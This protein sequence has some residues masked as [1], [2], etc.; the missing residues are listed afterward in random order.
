MVKSLTLRVH[1]VY[2]L[3]SL[4]ARFSRFND[5][6]MQF[7]LPCH[8]DHSVYFN[9]A[10]YLKCKYYADYIVIRSSDSAV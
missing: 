9:I 10:S 5:V 8:S 2:G 7:G 6:V 3:K 1:F 4:K